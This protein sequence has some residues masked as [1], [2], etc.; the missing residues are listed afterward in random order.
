MII[1]GPLLLLLAPLLLGAGL[2]ALSRWPRI[3]AMGGA[4]GAAVLWWLVTAVPLEATAPAA[5]GL[6][7][8]SEWVLLG[9]SFLLTEGIQQLFG[10]L[11]AA[12][13]LLCLIA[14]LMPQDRLFAPL[15]IIS[16]SPLAA[17]VMA[18]PFSFGILALLVAAAVL[19][20]LIQQERAGQT[21]AAMRFLVMMSL[22]IPLFLVA[23]W[24][25]ADGQLVFLGVV[26]RLLLVG[27]II[28]LA[29]FPFHIWVAPVLAE[30]SPPAAVV[31]FSLFPL[32][33]VVF[34]YQ[35]L[36][37]TPLWQLDIPFWT[38]LRFSGLIT[39]V[40]GAVL[41]LRA[42][43]YGRLL[44]AL[45]LIDM[46]VLILA[47]AAGEQLNLSSASMVLGLRFFSLLLAGSGLLFLR[48]YFSATDGAPDSFTAGRGLAR[49]YP[50]RVALFTYGILSLIGLPL[51]LGFSG[52][53]VAVLQ[54]GQQSPWLALILVLAT[55]AGTVG[56]LRA[57]V[58]LLA[59]PAE[60]KR[61]LVEGLKGESKVS[62]VI[63][64]LMLSLLLL[65]A[66]FPQILLNRVDYLMA[67]Y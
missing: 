59:P 8:G 3:A 4:P 35:L 29:G 62:Q 49:Q 52:R 22:A 58:H 43:A 15:S 25:L 50:G 37:E 64:G 12:V 6:S 27:F 54:A 11:T 45:L 48:P 30:A 16:L 26:A 39:A 46:G 23:D 28:L 38:A 61:P 7:A 41:A 53:W 14:A 57:L 17:V 67:L 20:A 47:L 24:M 5:G 18:R 32:V 33:L 60:A 42:E 65:L 2:L 21:L 36:L 34:G 13:G 44:A 40:L 51:T 66:L 1:P 31:I 9:R 19:A 63:I 55:G 10:W 56:L